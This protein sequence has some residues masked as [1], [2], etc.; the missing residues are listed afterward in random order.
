MIW[1]MASW[2]SVV[3]KETPERVAAVR[4]RFGRPVM[5]ALGIVKL[6]KTA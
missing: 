2:S 4:A 6:K 3:K 1:S 5:K